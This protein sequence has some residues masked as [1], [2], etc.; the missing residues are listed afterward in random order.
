LIGESCRF[1]NDSAGIGQNFYGA[2]GV[3]RISLCAR[4]GKTPKCRPPVHN[5]AAAIVMSAKDMVD[6]DY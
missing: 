5:L 6:A 4:S 1:S 3:K 2:F